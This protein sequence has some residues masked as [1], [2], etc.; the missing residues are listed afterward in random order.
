MAKSY[1]P[2]AI[3]LDIQLP[4]I[5]GWSVMGELKSSAVTRHIPVHVISVV[6]E[7]KQGLMMGAIAYLK[8]PSSREALEDA[9]THIESY[10]EKSMKHLLIVEDDDIQRNSIIELI[11]HDD[12]SITAA[13]TGAEAL[14]ELRKQRYDCMAG[15]G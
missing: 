7:V 15:S 10:A 13:S 1:K 2:D 8:K 9:F 11:G 3:I 4:V 12:V 14:S 5:D 6:D